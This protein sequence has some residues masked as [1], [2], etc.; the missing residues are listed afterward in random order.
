ME[1]A[2]HEEDVRKQI[3]RLGPWFQNIH[4]PGGI[5]TCS[6]H[7][8]GDYPTFKWRLLEGALPRDL[9]GWTALDIGCNAG[10]YTFELAKRG[11]AVTGMDSNPHY[12][13]QARWV[14][15]QLGMAERVRLVERS[16]YELARSHEH[17]DLV[18]FMG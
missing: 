5:E 18:L 10:F 12:L 1:P 3:E 14:A 8:L 16:V 2:H 13:R 7:Y 15:Q 17:Y 6:D 4:L 11:A 9:H